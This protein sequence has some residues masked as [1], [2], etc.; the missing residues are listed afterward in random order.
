MAYIVS[1][2]KKKNPTP[3]PA[4]E[5][6]DTLQWNVTNTDDLLVVAAL[7]ALCGGALSQKHYNGMSI[8]SDLLH[9]AQFQ[10]LYMNI[11]LAKSLKT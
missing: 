2:K 10:N 1:K 7:A 4:Y 6:V 3:S 5:A 11:F 8:T 9:L